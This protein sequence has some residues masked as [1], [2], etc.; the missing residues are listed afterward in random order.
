ME[1]LRLSVYK[2]NKYI[3]AQIIDDTKGE[4]LASS[5]GTNPEAV[6][7]EIA[8]K[9]TKKKVKDVVFDRG[10]FR[11]HGKIKLLADAARRGGLKF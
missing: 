1:K 3:Y 10:R 6:G 4:T 11:Y 7:D 8:K 2:S 5:K 9:A